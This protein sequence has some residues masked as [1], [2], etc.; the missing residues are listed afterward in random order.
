MFNHY[1]GNFTKS[2]KKVTISAYPSMF[3]QPN[4]GGD[5]FISHIHPSNQTLG[6]MNSSL[7]VWMILS[8]PYLT[9]KQTHPQ[10]MSRRARDV[11]WGRMK[12]QCVGVQ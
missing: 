12:M 11:G 6:G 1:E 5:E 10:L 3:I 4:N 7:T 2:Y 9:L 8:H